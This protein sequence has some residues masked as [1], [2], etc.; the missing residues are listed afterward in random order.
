MRDMKRKKGRDMNSNR[1]TGENVG[2]LLN[3]VGDVVAKDTEMAKILNVFSVFV[4]TG[5]T[6]L[7]ESQ[8]P[9]SGEKVR[10]KENT[11]VQVD[12]LKE[13]L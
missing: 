8:A 7:Q 4:F 11:S 6:V 2:M 5:K 3:M 12:Y 10:K 9:N 1:K 13:L